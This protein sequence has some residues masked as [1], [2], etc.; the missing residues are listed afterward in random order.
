MTVSIREAYGQALVR[1]GSTD[2]RVVVLDADVAASTRSALFAAACPERFF[3]VGIAE[4]NMAAMAA[5]LASEGKIP[6]VNT[7]AIFMATLGAL[8]ARTFAGYGRLNIKFMGAYSGVSDAFD[9]AS[10][11]SVEDLAIMRAIPGIQVYVASDAVLTDWLVR[12]ALADPQPMYIRLSRDAMP[13]LYAANES[14]TA[15][16]GK[17][18]RPGEDVTVLTCGILGSTALA[19]AR[20]LEQEGCSVRVVD[21]FSIKPI[22]RDLISR[23]A[24]ETR[25]IVTAEEHSTIGGLGSAVAE[26]LAE[27]G[28]GVPLLRLGIP[29]CYTQS[30]C[31]ASLMSCY[32]LDSAGLVRSIRTAWA[33]LR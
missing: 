15:G 8:S 11:H 3:N 16:Q 2:T 22:D 20:L 5:G 18:L 13:A 1:Y 23:C 27:G 32:G 33:D 17:L 4:A 21:L 9:G 6:F 31:Y 25:L 29:D 19:A 12:H 7:F 30:G 24:R 10:H 28:A 26:V 14:F